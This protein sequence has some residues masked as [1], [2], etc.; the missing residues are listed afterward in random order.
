MSKNNMYVFIQEFKVCHSA[1]NFIAIFMIN[2]L[3]LLMYLLSMTVFI[4]L[5]RCAH[6]LSVNSFKRKLKMSS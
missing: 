1:I 6:K 5:N 2:F 3:L 4:F